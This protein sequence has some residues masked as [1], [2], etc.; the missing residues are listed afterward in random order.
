MKEYRGGSQN[1]Y[2]IEPRDF[3][4]DTFIS[5]DQAINS[6]KVDDS[7]PNVKT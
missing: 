4:L 3:M 1:V 7:S 2:W 5:E 6:F